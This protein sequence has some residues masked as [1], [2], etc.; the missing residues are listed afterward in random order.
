MILTAAGLIL[1]EK[2]ILLVKRVST[3]LLFPGCWACPGGKAEKGETPKIAA[4]REVKE[5]TNLDFEPTT[6]FTINYYQDREMHRFFGNWSGEIKL[7]ESEIVDSAWLTYNEAKDLDFAFD[8][9]SIL[10]ELRSRD[11]L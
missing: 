5:E 1:D 9:K 6:L 11:I 8:Y 3:T 10:E 2:K 4:V 7:Q